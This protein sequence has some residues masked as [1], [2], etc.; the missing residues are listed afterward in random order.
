[1]DATVVGSRRI[2]NKT[3]EFCTG[4][5][6]VAFLRSLIGV[7]SPRHSRECLI[8]VEGAVET[9]VSFYSTLSESVTDD[10][11]VR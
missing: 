7:S 8:P 4:A 11:I 1:M 6:A 9:N 3:V 2:T 5:E 10:T